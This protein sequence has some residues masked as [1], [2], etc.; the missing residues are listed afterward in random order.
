MSRGRELME[1]AAR[2]GP[3]RARRLPGR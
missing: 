2:P 1:L 3:P